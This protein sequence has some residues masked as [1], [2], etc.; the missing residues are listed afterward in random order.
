IDKNERMQK[1]I[2]EVLKLLDRDPRSVEEFVQHIATLNKVNSDLA[3]LDVEF[4]TISKMFHIVKDFSM[5][6][7]PEAYALFRSLAPIY[8]QLK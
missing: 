5:N 4:E 1:T 3:N 7:A 8:H 2:R 6:I